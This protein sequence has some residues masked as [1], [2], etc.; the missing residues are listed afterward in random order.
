M[1]KYKWN[2]ANL[3][4][5]HLHPKARARLCMLGKGV[6]V[7]WV[8][9]WLLAAAFLLAGK[10]EAGP[11]EYVHLPLIFHASSVNPPEPAVFFHKGPDL[12][13]TGDN[14]HMKI[15][16]HLD[17]A[18]TS[19]LQWGPDTGYCQGSAAVTEFDPD[20]QYA[21]TITGLTP[22][23]KV[24]YRITGDTGNATGTFFAA[25]N[26]PA[27]G[28]KF[29][30]YGDTRSDLAVHDT[31]AGRIIS[32]YTADP[33]FQTF[34]LAVGDLV[35]D[36]DLD[37]AWDS[38]FFDP[39]YANI[40]A[41]L[42]NISF[43]SVMGNHEGSG[44]LFSKYFPMPFAA[45]RYWSF[46]YGPAHFVM[47]DQYVPYEVG[48]TQYTWL[49]NDLAASSKSW[50]FIVLHEPGWSAGGGHENNETVQTLIQPLAEL[51][52]VSIVFEGHNHYYARA[53]VNG[54]QHLTVGGGGAPLHTP[55][56]AQPFIVT[57]SQSHGFVMITI[58]G[59]KLTCTA[60]KS[61]GT[62]IETFEIIR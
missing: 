30:A 38:E 16:W 17:S 24:Y 29:F 37:T 26:S 18:I 57:T 23:L 7:L 25:P 14:T 9:G 31:I 41:I 61:D 42:A 40:R 45:D 20:H 10:A 49:V 62:V 32:T 39:Q 4:N 56:P 12:V 3:A 60:V 53:V 27:S 46:D 22:G 15:V 52:G 50:K 1:D 54:V 47:L 43:L 28:L 6:M 35:S 19:T 21:Y 33:G 59:N 51:Y 5:A 8:T 13:L 2:P 58:D 55:D 36:G 48:S 44:S 11:S 34:K